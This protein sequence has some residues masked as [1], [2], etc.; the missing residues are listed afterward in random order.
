MQDIAIVLYRY[1]AKIDA[2]PLPEV[3]RKPFFCGVSFITK[4][5]INHSSLSKESLNK[6]NMHEIIISYGT[7][8]ENFDK[9]NF[10]RLI[11]IFKYA[12]I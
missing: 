4:K 8:W 2:L 12:F 5:L 6:S 11:L 1:Q 10:S 3:G 9:E 7:L